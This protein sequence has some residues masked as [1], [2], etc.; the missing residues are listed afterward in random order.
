[1]TSLVAVVSL[2][3]AFVATAIS[4]VTFLRTLAGQVPSVDFLVERDESERA[5]YTLRVS[6]PTRRVLVLDYVEVLSPESGKVF[7]WPK[8][9]TD[10]GV[11]ERALE[12]VYSSGPKHVKPVFLAVP[13]GQSRDVEVKFRLAEDEEFEVS[14]GLRWSRGLPLPDRCFL[15]RSIELDAAQIKS[16]EI[17]AGVRTR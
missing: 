7:M 1:M 14:F 11:T 8:G 10:H 3:F 2:A 9:V 16:R 15:A 12:E 17:A 6:N 5:R 13:A 4:V